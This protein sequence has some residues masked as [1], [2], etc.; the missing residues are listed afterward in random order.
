[1]S[2]DYSLLNCKID[3]HNN[4]L[5]ERRKYYQ[6]KEGFELLWPKNLLIMT[7]EL[8]FNSMIHWSFAFLDFTYLVFQTQRCSAKSH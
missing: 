5:K 3:V 7:N 4:K 2:S 6:F 8:D 1:M